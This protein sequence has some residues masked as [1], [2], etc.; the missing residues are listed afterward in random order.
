MINLP[1]ELMA[2][3]V[4]AGWNQSRKI[5]VPSFI[6][7]D[8]PA[9][10]VL[11]Q[12]GGLTVGKCEPGIECATS[13]IV[14]RASQMDE[15]DNELAVWQRLLD[16]TLVSIGEVHHGHGELFLS[17]DSR[18]FGRSHIHDAFYFEGEDF[19]TGIRNLLLGVRSRPMLRPDQDVVTMYGISYTSASPETYCYSFR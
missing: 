7:P 5:E 18:C 6:P 3:F 15:G 19:L 2:E 1:M 9:K 14:F 12:F 8:H 4:K 11:A 10:Q 17:A 13:D 16:T